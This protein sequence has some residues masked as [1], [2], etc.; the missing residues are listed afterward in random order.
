MRCTM[1][2]IFTA[3]LRDPGLEGACEP[4]RIRG[5][6]HLPWRFTPERASSFIGS[7]G[8]PRAALKN[9]RGSRECHLRPA[10]GADPGGRQGRG[11]SVRP[12]TAVLL[13]LQK[14]LDLLLHEL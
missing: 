10:R 14:A 4:C 7:K 3:L 11:L 13:I 2:D 9:R 12:S 8:K 6:R 5:S 1:S